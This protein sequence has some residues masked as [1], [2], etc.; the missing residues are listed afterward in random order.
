M[1][2]A[3]LKPETPITSWNKPPFPSDE[4]GESYSSNPTSSTTLQPALI[5]AEQD[6][7]PDFLRFVNAL[8]ALYPQGCNEKRLL[9]AMLLAVP[10]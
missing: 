1:P 9:D 4:M 2:K 8:S 6:R 10:R 5:K 3:P 7:G